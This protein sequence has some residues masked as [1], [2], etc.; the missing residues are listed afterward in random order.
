M[1]RVPS[2][3]N[4]G[5]AWQRVN[6]YKMKDVAAMRRLPPEQRPDCE[7]QGVATMKRAGR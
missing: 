1:G 3:K 4:A 2:G 5:G 7:K 6:K